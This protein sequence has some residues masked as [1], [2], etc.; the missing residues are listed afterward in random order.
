[1]QITRAMEMVAA[2]GLKRAELRARQ[3][4]QF[5]TKMAQIVKHLTGS[6]EKS[7][8]LFATRQVNKR[9]LVV[10]T[11][12]RGLCGA[13]NSSVISA[14]LKWLKSYPTDQVEL[15]LLGKKGISF[16]QEKPWKIR[17]VVSGWGG[18]ITF[19]E[20]RALTTQ[21][22]NDYLEGQLDEVHLVYTH[23]ISVMNRQ[24]VLEKFLNLPLPGE[25]GPAREY[26]FEPSPEAIFDEILP[27]YCVEKMGSL[28][29]E[30]YASELAARTFSMRQATKN[31]EEMSEKL[32]L[33]RNK[34][35]QAGITREMIEITTGAQG[36]LE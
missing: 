20:V 34:I 31:A 30:S 9:G 11:A 36:V 8:P 26:L 10:V 28:L 22:V 32:T 4:F 7:H 3:S 6:T 29:D 17:K 1:M 5:M 12:D 27:K 25:G 15:I 13:Y 19:P 21:I 23:F 16:F 14:A 2:T 35:R 24:V 18:K 33:T